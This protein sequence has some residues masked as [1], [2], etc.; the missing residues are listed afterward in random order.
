LYF[1]DFEKAMD[2]CVMM[3]D[4]IN[5]RKEGELPDGLEIAYNLED[6]KIRFAKT[7]SCK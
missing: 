5:K 4:I 3:M 2:Y 7:S 1:D 6:A